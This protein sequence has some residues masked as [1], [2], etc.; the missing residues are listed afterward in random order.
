MTSPVI[1]LGQS[2]QGVTPAAA[3]HRGRR[4]ARTAWAV[5]HARTAWAVIH[6]RTA[7]AVIHA[8]TAWAVIHARTAWAITLARTALSLTLVHRPPGAWGKVV[9]YP[10]ESLHTDWAL[11][12]VVFHSGL[13]AVWSELLRGLSLISFGMGRGNGLT[14]PCEPP[15]QTTRRFTAAAASHGGEVNILLFHAG[16]LAA[17][18]VLIRDLTRDFVLGIGSPIY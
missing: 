13:F 9:F 18:P 8:R 12:N 3:S 2:T 17:R 14:S 1:P 7:W 6:A 10:V 4:I 15:G 16:F 11:Q 5:T